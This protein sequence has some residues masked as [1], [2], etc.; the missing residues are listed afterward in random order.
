[1]RSD[2]G[3]LA[4][5]VIRNRRSTPIMSRSC[6]PALLLLTVL[7]LCFGGSHA[8]PLAT[9]RPGPSAFSQGDALAID[10]RLNGTSP[11]NSFFL[12][13]F[14]VCNFSLTA[15]NTMSKGADVRLNLSGPK[16]F[17]FQDEKRSETDLNRTVPWDSFSLSHNDSKTFNFLLA[18]NGTVSNGTMTVMLGFR[19]EGGN[20]TQQLLRFYLYVMNPLSLLSLGFNE[21][22][23]FIGETVSLTLA[24]RNNVTLPANMTLTLGLGSGLRT[25]DHHGILNR[26]IA[27]LESVDWVI[28]VIVVNKINLSAQVK[29]VSDFRSGKDHAAHEWHM[30]IADLT[31]KPEVS[32]TVNSSNTKVGLGQP[33]ELTVSLANNGFC[34]ATD[35]DLGL[36][37]LGASGE[38]RSSELNASFGNWNRSMMVR[39]NNSN[40][41]T[42]IT[43]RR[44]LVPASEGN[45]TITIS[46]SYLV[47]NSIHQTVE[48]NATVRIK[49]AIAT[50][51]NV[52]PVFLG[53]ALNV[54]LTAVRGGTP[55]NQIIGMKEDPAWHQTTDN[56]GAVLYVASLPQML[57]PGDHYVTFVF[58]GDYS[59]GTDLLPSE[60]RSNISGGGVLIG[61]GLFV[62]VVVP[63]VLVF[64]RKRGH[65]LPE[66]YVDIA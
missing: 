43:I 50:M 48:K 17:V 46:I 36:V 2:D 52:T 56:S 27:G 6:L 5:S 53:C 8:L 59:S 58:K 49:P 60:G 37:V 28:P 24:V 29:L 19:P 16:G 26:T 4:A 34:D 20:W 64:F 39:P 61:L 1:M 23:A 62:V 15:K 63:I 66:D 54:S 42:I 41:R 9:S 57:I 47:N 44:N 22:E 14:E 33:V 7:G 30:S 21:T 32:I 35:F 38:N 25:A 10:I 45:A 31:V 12:H 13:F 51:I 11:G 55:A 18:Q 40:N 3:F 65:G